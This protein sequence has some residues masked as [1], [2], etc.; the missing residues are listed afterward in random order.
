VPSACLIRYA[1]DKHAASRQQL[2]ELREPLLVPQ[3]ADGQVSG[4]GDGGGSG[5]GPNGAAAA[6]RQLRPTFSWWGSRLFWAGVLLQL[7]AAAVAV[8]T[9]LTVAGALPSP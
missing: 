8:L 1:L 9:V 6:V 2:A 4:S 5:S 7:L 3:E